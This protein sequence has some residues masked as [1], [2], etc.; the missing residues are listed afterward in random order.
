MLNFLIVLALTF[1]FLNGFHDAANSIATVVS[2]RVLRPLQAVAWSAAFN[3]LAIL[4]LQTGVAST[5]AM[6]LV[7]QPAIDAAVIFGGLAGAIAWSLIAARLG[8]AAG[9]AHALV[10]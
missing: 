3:F 1:G 10:S 2:T 4:L 9:S 7:H 8:I 6:G 5:I